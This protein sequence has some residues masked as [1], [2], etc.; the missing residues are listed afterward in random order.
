MEIE[1]LLDR[2]LGGIYGQ[3][4][5]DAF[6]M[7]AMLRP[8]V[9]KDRYGVITDLIDAPADHPVHHGLK[10][11]QITDDTEQAISLAR[12]IIEEGK[13]TVEGAARA[14]VMWYDLVDGDHSD[15]VG[16]S[17]RK[18]VARLKKGADPR[19]TGLQG[20]TDGGAMR[21]SPVGLINPGSLEQAVRDTSIACIP[22]HNTDA[23]ISGAAAIAGAISC[24]MTPDSTLDAIIASGRQAAEMGLR[25]GSP[26]LGASIPRR[27][28]LAVKLA[29]Q[30]K[31]IYDC[32]VDIYDL[33]GC[34]L[35]T[36]EAVPA[37]F[38][39][40]FLARGEV[41]KCA[42]YA[43]MMSGDADTVGA[44]ACAIAGAWKG[45]SAFPQSIIQKLNQA[46]PGWDFYGTGQGLTDLILARAG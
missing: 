28:D 32:L 4:L 30:Q 46:N 8:E 13:V 44:M 18:A 26:W 42:Q 27:I 36:T 22:S 38:G 24:A 25:Y 14:L 15:Y 2:V 16:P 12:V 33:V 23:A 41:M 37:A 6:A 21:I 40:L 29:G 3:A 34:G 10:A 39:V 20:D 11:G 19:T 31:D 35:L 9:T 1:Y 7:P 43:V 45:F 17:T 5:G